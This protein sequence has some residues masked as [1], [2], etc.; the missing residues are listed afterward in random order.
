MPPMSE[1]AL[2][3]GLKRGDDEAFKTLVR[4]YGDYLYRVALRVTRSETEAGEAV[5]EALI[6]TFRSI[7]SFES[8]S[9]LKT[10]LHRLVVNSALMRLRS[11]ERRAEVSIDEL[12]PE[13][14]DVREEP[15]WT[16]VESVEAALERDSVRAA[17]TQAMGRLPDRYR[18]L[19]VLRDI[20]GFDTHEVAQLLGDTEGNVKVRLH[21]ARAALKTLLEPL[22]RQ[23][24]V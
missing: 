15:E 1:A 24:A 13:I 7:A 22:Y 17:V 2:I 6:G 23:E 12:V 5:Q 4:Q 16:F 8:R 14:E 21:R 11:I 10:W 18:I 20:E 19:L 9:T 3:E